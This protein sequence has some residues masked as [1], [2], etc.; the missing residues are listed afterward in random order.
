[1]MSEDTKMTEQQNKTKRRAN[2]YFFAKMVFNVIL[3]L[4]GS[5]LISILLRRMQTT[6]SLQKQKQNSLQAIEQVSQVIE[7][8]RESAEELTGVFHAGNRQMLNDVEMILSNGLFASMQN[9][10]STIQAEI[11]ANIAERSQTKLLFLMDR[12]GT[13]LLSPDESL[14]G[15]N[16]AVPAYMTQENVNDLLAS[17]SGGTDAPEYVRVKNR[18][19]IFYFYA[20]PYRYED[21]EYVLAIGAEADILDHQTEELT[22]VESVLKRAAV[23]NDGFL[24]AVDPSD[25][26][27]R[28]YKNGNELLTG[29]KVL[30]CGLSE[31][32]LTAGYSGTQRI[33]GREYYVVSEE[34]P[35]HTVISAAAE[36]DVIRE[37]VNYVA[38]WSVLA[39]NVIM[40]LCLA[41]AVIVRNDFVRREVQTDRIV[42]RA[43]SKDPIYLDKSIFKKIFPLLLTGI[44]A[45]FGLSFYTQTLLEVTEGIE[46]SEV[47]LQEV[48]GRYEESQESRQLINQYHDRRFLTTAA[49][50]SLG[51]EEDPAILN[52]ESDRYHSIYGEDN[53]KV[54][55]TDDEG[56]RLKS[57]ANSQALKKLCEANGIN[58]I[59]IYDEN[60]RTIAT[61]TPNWFFRISHNE[62]DQSYPFLDVIDGRKD[63]YIQERMVNDLGK[64]SRYIGTVFHYYTAK[65]E[66]GETL[67][68]SRFEYEDMINGSGLTETEEGSITAHR[69]MIQI[70]LDDALTDS[71]LEATDV[72][73]ILSSNMLDG[74]S[75]TMF[76]TTEDHVCLYS[77]L[78][79]NVGK[80]A[81]DLGIPDKAFLSENYFGFNR[82]GTETYFQYFRY[83]DGYY[84]STAIPRSSMFAARLPIAL[85][86]SAI[87]F[88]LILVLSLTITLTDRE[89]EKLYES[90]NEEMEN[91]NNAAVYSIIL[92]SGRTTSTVT[93]A[94][95]WSNR[96]LS[97][98]E[99]SP[100]QKLM[101]MIKVIC[102]LMMIYVLISVIGAENLLHRKSIIKYIIYSSWDRGWNIFA[103]TS[104]VMIMTLTIVSVSLCRF[105]VQLVVSLFGTRGET[106]GHLL[107]SVLKYGG[108]IGAFFYCLYLVGMD[109]GNVLASAGI[110]S[111]VIGLGAQSLITD[112]IAG[113][114]IVFEGEFR[115]GDI[116]TIDGT[117]GTVMDIGLRTTKI[118]A[119]GG[120]IKIY[121]NSQISGVLN[122]TKEASVA[123]ATISI[124]YGQDIDYVEAVMK[125]ELPALREKN[126]LILDGPTYLGVS[127][128]GA[129][130]ID[131]LVICKCFEKD[132]KGMNRYLNAEILKIFYRNG[133]NVP[134]PNVTISQLDMTGRKTIE[135][136][137]AEEEQKAEEADKHE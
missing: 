123:S 107:L 87:C 130:G 49:L 19:G 133:I 15:L 27:F 53:N 134:F 36:Y 14:I 38:F 103:L 23:I 4:V 109:S 136:F 76:D 42:L 93:A 81:A 111:L 57:V 108:A 59:Y 45:M 86:T 125:R 33:G 135:D 75:I 25:K 77:P 6:A 65:D 78:E 116:V 28:Y 71:L 69:S 83:L 62:G 126:D 61:S 18:F 55:L 2:V 120:N 113:I 79:V 41:Y 35:D 26:I 95:R 64:T 44:M 39:F 90:I 89:E 92:P 63:S 50:V 34:L 13:V 30:E 117:R 52:E 31:E 99:R 85:I 100:E 119:P 9:A 84:I 131:V 88:V 60:G 8:N 82:V 7:R 17:A 10:D 73:S 98:S 5:A 101:L 128:L 102:I 127:N 29:Q 67:Y 24:F 70:E 51:A 106:L 97:W 12:D 104:C 56:N 72:S 47:A 94:A 16:P 48:I 1:M 22:N 74:G 91:G 3:L 80:K 96:H 137:K 11:F 66:N 124:E 32:A 122:M 105:P 43:N 46:K 132:V 118:Q 115:V 54:Y 114:F 58:E 110:L 129:S 121:N 20:M 68:V 112:I 40:I 37:D 21:Q